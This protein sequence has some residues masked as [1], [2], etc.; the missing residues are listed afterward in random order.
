M[1]EF[2]GDGGPDRLRGGDD[3][4]VMRGLG[5]SDRLIG[6]RGRDVVNGGAGHDLLRGGDGSDLLYGGGG[7]DL[8]FGHGGGGRDPASGAIAAT[9][10]ATGLTNPVFAAAAP[11]DPGHLYVSELRTGD[12]KILDLATKTVSPTPFLNLDSARLGQ[13]GEQGFLGFAFHPDFAT[14][15]QLFVSIVDPDGNTEILRFTTFAGDPMRID[16]AS[17]TLVWTFPRNQPY[18]NHTGGWIEFGPDGYLY[19]ASG[20]GGPGGDQNNFGQD[21]DTLLGK[22]LRID[23]DGDDFPGNPSRNYAIPSDNPFADGGGR[24]EIW[25]YGLRHPWRNSFDSATGDLYIADVGQA[26]IEEINWQ[27]AASAGGENYGWA[28]MEG[29]QVFDGD[30]PGNPAPGDPVLVDPVHAYPHSEANGVSVTGGYVYRG[31]SAGMDGFYIFGDFGS[32]RLATFRMHEGEAADFT[33]LIDR[34]VPD[35]GEIGRIVSFGEDNREN[36][37]VVAF[38]GQVYRL[39][40]SPG[41]ADGADQIAAGGGNDS[42]Y[43]EAGLDILSGE[44]GNDLLSGGLGEDRLLGGGGA[45]RL[46]GDGGDDL[47]VGGVGD[48][49]SRG[50]G[51]ADTLRFAPGAGADRFLDF[52]GADLLD[53]EAFGFADADEALGHARDLGNGNVVFRFD[54]GSSLIVADARV[55]TLADQ[56]LI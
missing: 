16:P 12:I 21:T 36:L 39:D 26:R 2:T 22:M 53:L 46:R 51:G 52:G 9:R 25:A 5:G 56:I 35:V 37:Y 29:D 24:P 27:P 28:V 48:D 11:G 33:N 19:L 1:A 40:P 8:I 4:D 32:G 49:D 31:P 6:G 14:N 3:A 54:D 43:G 55:E 7:D 42:V 34:V 38:S 50:G 10:I 17:E 20:D 41:A 18:T 45:D 23:V 30:R 47:L 15:R 44:A 13:S